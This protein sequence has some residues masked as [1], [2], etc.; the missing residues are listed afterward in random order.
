MAPGVDSP[1]MGKVHNTRYDAISKLTR[2]PTP[3][4]KIVEER[5]Q[6]A[7]ED[8]PVLISASQVFS[9]KHFLLRRLLSVRNC[10]SIILL[11]RAV[12]C[13]NTTEGRKS[14]TQWVAEARYGI[15]PDKTRDQVVHHL[16]SA[17]SGQHVVRDCW[18]GTALGD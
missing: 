7:P 4:L 5:R 6:A 16:S 9:V 17:G 3:E 14:S 2:Y 1:T 13:S 11:S 15:R 8:A 18:Q 12:F 10:A